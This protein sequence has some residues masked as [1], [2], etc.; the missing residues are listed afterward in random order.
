MQNDLPF[1]YREGQDPFQLMTDYRKEIHNRIYCD[2][3]A[4]EMV[5]KKVIDPD[6]RKE[7][8]DEK[9]VSV[10]GREA[11]LTEDGVKIVMDVLDTKINKITPMATLDRNEC[12]RSAVELDWAISKAIGAD[13]D[14]FLTNEKMD[15]QFDSVL[16]TVMNL[17]YDFNKLAEKGAFREW[18]KEILSVQYN[19]ENEIAEEDKG[20]LGGLRGMFNR[21]PRD[22]AQR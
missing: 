22:N 4:T 18:A 2:L 10:P 15:I 17:I 6:T 8:W 13:L 21:Q 9:P 5:W 19:R 16:D 11:V 14:E 12:I 7:R 3:T 1:Q 20:L